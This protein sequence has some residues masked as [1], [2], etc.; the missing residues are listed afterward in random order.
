LE[1]IPLN[2][3]LNVDMCNSVTLLIRTQVSVMIIIFLVSS[4]GLSSVFSLFDLNLLFSH[5]CPQIHRDF[6]ELANHSR[7]RYRASLVGYV[8]MVQRAWRGQRAR[9][10]FEQLIRSM[11]QSVMQL[12]LSGP[13][14]NKPSDQAHSTAAAES[15]LASPSSSSSSDSVTIPAAIGK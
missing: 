7:W 5:G 1:G 9:R 10:K 2:V 4:A 15:D 13:Y 8:V 11:R 14:F 12:E 3:E 6:P